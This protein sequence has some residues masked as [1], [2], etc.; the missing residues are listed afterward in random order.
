M[1]YYGEQK[2]RYDRERVARERRRFFRG[3]CCVDCSSRRRLELDHVDPSTKISHNVWSWSET[4]RRAEIEKCVIRCHDCH[5]ERHARE[6][7]KPDAHGTRNCYFR[8]RCRCPKC[9]KCANDYRNN[10]RYRTGKRVKG[11]LGGRPI[12]K[13]AGV[14]QR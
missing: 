5:V 13:I 12:L 14:A 6:A 1:P 8:Y 11:R 10:Q 2:R 3:K 7:R 4:R 9:V